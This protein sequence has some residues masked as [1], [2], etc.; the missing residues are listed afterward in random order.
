MRKNLIAVSVLT[1]AAFMAVPFFAQALSG[2]N[3]DEIDV[4]VDTKQ[5]GDWFRAIKKETTDKSVLKVKDVLPGWYKFE[6][7]TED[8]R[9]GQSL[10]VELR[11]LDRDGRKVDEKTDVDLSWMV[12]DTEVAI[13][14]ETNADGWLKTE[15]LSFDTEYKMDISDKDDV[16]LGKKDGKARVRVKAKIDD[17][18]WFK[19]FYDRTDENN[20]L[21]IGR[22]L[23]GKYKFK[24]KTGDRDPALPFTLRIRMTDEKGEIVDDETSYELYAY[25]GKIRV[26]VG[27]VLT[28]EDGWL[29]LPGIMSG[30]K[31]KIKMAD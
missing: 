3:V 31:Y 20:I 25:M 10:A 11:M 9:S 15:D 13:T 17:S 28:D 6:R 8:T 4:K 26:P 18:D 23:P 27:T 1:C 12:G 29:T 21:K 5:G 24:Y 2:A 19:A 14:V 22:V 16:S 30:M 7:R